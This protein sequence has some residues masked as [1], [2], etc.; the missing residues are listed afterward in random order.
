[1]TEAISL[2]ALSQLIGSIYD[3]ALE[4]DRWDR[5]LSDLKDAFESQTSS[6]GLIDKRRGRILINKNAGAKPEW[7]EQQQ[8]HHAAEINAKLTD[9]FGRTSLDEPHVLSRHFARLDWETSGYLQVCQKA[10]VTDM[11]AYALVWEPAYFSVFGVAKMVQQG[12]V[13]DRDI[14]LG[15]LLLPHLRRAVTISK[16]L[17][18]HAIEQSRM[19]EAL[20]VLKCGVV[21]TDGGGAILHANR[22]A[23]RMFRHGWFIQSTRGVVAAKLP[24]AAKELRKAIKLAARDESTLGKTG[25]AI[26]LSEPDEPA[27]FAHVLPLTGG[28]LR[29]GLEP[30]AAAAVFIGA[31]QDEEEAAQAMAAAF[32]LTPAETRLL[33]SLLAGRTLA[34]T[35]M[36]RGVA[37][38]TAKTHLDSI[39]QKT[40]VN[41]QAELIRLAARA[42]P[43]AR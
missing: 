16:V 42:T 30:A 4:P 39:F 21:L 24:E 43:P 17:D 6:V 25:L 27:I 1:M 15:G 8:T 20:D 11:M 10:G 12:I 26:R 3:C 19:A 29:S 28:D 2:Q 35:A 14:A 38:T 31:E 36:A 22:A 18:A 40:G 7:L 32:G 23:E 41:R 33:E 9:Y 37:I 5:T 13:T 34:E